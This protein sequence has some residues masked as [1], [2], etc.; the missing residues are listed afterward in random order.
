[1]IFYSSSQIHVIA[2][3]WVRK[4]LSELKKNLLWVKVFQ[5]NA[6]ENAECV[7]YRKVGELGWAFVNLNHSYLPRLLTILLVI[8]Y[9]N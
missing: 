5:I 4:K 1:M 9:N 8:D 2:R 7:D 6:S 3:V